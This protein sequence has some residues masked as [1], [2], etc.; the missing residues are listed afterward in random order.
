M[1]IQSWTPKIYFPLLVAQLAVLAVEP[2]HVLSWS[3]AFVLAVIAVTLFLCWRRLRLSV[4]HNHSLWT[5]L[6]LAVIAQFVAFSLLL[7]DS[8]VN[9]QGTLVAVDP[10]FYFCLNSLLLTIAAAYRP[11][12]ALYRWTSIMDGFLA[13]VIAV[14]FYV[15]L[16]RV[17]GRSATDPSAAIFIMWLFDAMAAF[18]ALFATLRFVSTKRADER[19]FFF[20]LM[21]FSWVEIVFP[22]IHNRFILSSESYLPEIFLSLPFVILG[23]LLSR[24]RTVWFRSYRPSRRI[25]ILA[26]SVSPFVLSVA[27]CCVA[28]GQLQASPIL[29]VSALILGVASY[30]AR[31]GMILSQHLAIEDK[32]RRLQR[33]LQQAIVKDDLTQLANRRGFYRAFKREW[34]SALAQHTRLIVAMVDIDYFKLFNDTYGHLAGDDCLATVGQALQLEAGLHGSALVAR[35]GGEEFAVLLPGQDRAAAEHILQRLRIRVEALQI[36]H[37]RTPLGVVTVSAGLASSADGEYA[38]GEKLLNAADAALY[39]AKRAGRNCIRWYDPEETVSRNGDG[40]VSGGQ[41]RSS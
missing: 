20:V 4:V 7:A 22:A 18:V 27:L 38:D 9:P 36:R 32:L 26:R 28:F 13:C 3:Y 29:A 5:L 23:V 15:L 35:Y 41:N 11:A 30:A 14:F 2:A 1:K 19:R 34:D 24:R 21:A 40:G 17:V 6:L 8:W 39:E 33:D 31:A 37:S 12:G 10:T 25:R 16:H